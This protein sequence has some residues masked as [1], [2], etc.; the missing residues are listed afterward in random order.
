APQHFPYAADQLECLEWLGDK[1]IELGVANDRRTLAGDKQ[2]L[3]R[4]VARACALR[5]LEAADPAG[6]PNIGDQHIERSL[7]DDAQCFQAARRGLDI[8]TAGRQHLADR[9]A[10]PIVILDNQYRW[11]PIGH[12][13]A[14]VFIGKTTTTG[15]LKSSGPNVSYSPKKI[16]WRAVR[17]PPSG[18]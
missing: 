15:R 12:R 9:L 3:E 16:R 13:H 10:D 17:D 18:A 6:Q 14:P 4:R 7:V 2:A 11:H 5:H 8:K 1:I